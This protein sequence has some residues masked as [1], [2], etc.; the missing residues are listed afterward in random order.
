MFKLYRDD[1]ALF[2]TRHQWLHSS[3]GG[4]VRHS[5]SAYCFSSSLH[6]YL[7]KVPQGRLYRL[8]LALMLH[9]P[10]LRAW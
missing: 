5:A 10:P 3:T 1:S 4:A 2:I 8:Q 6:R 7:G 9:L